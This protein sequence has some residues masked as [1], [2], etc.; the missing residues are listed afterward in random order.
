MRTIDQT[1]IDMIRVLQKRGGFTCQQIADRFDIQE[2]QVRWIMRYP[3]SI[4]PET[5]NSMV[6]ATEVS[7]G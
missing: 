2:N 7:N 6:S 3:A 4:M 1:T 5:L